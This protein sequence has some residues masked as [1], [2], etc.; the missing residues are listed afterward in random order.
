[1]DASGS[2]HGTATQRQVL[3]QACRAQAHTISTGILSRI[4]AL[5]TKPC[6]SGSKLW[7]TFSNA[8]LSFSAT[9][10]GASKKAAMLVLAQHVF[11]ITAGQAR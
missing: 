6:T 9:V 7:N 11:G 1:M 4:T 3:S 8:N 10:R 5:E 2:E